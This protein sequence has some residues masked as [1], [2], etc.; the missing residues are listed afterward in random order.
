MR[1]NLFL[2]GL[3]A[4]GL[5]GCGSSGTDGGIPNLTRVEQTLP[6]SSY[7]LATAENQPSVSGN[8][9]NLVVLGLTDDADKV[10]D[11]MQLLAQDD[12]SINRI[13]NT[14]TGANYEAEIQA[15]NRD[16]EL[17]VLEYQGVT[18]ASGGFASFNYLDLGGLAYWAT[19]GALLSGGLP[20][21][22]AVYT[23]Y[24]A[25][26]ERDTGMTDAGSLTLIANFSSLSADLNINTPL[27]TVSGTGLRI[28]ANSGRIDGVA[29]GAL[30]GKP[31]SSGVVVGYFAGTG[32]EG[33]H[34]AFFG[35][36]D[37]VNAVDAAFYGNR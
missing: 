3:V 22:T 14:V 19:D 7:G 26:S 36:Q 32:A 21:G 2:A 23:G 20:V 35:N 16:G 33:V 34:G 11:F 13:S 17:G 10:A 12:P 18:L 28:D 25:T 6:T 8:D 27:A 5:I 15:T 9:Y 31:N 24:A 37:S 30:A 29:T 1:C 4:V